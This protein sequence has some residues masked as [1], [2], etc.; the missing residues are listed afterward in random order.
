MR[1]STRAPARRQHQV[2]VT[3]PSPR[4]PEHEPRSH[5]PTSTPH[6]R[7]DGTRP[8]RRPTAQPE[9]HR[10]AT[11][12]VPRGS[13]PGKTR[14]LTHLA[15]EPHPSLHVSS[16]VGACA[17]ADDLVTALISDL[18]LCA[19]SPSRKSPARSPVGARR[20]SHLRGA[21]RGSSRHRLEHSF[22]VVLGPTDTSARMCSVHRRGTEPNGGGVVRLPG[23]GAHMAGRGGGIEMGRHL[24]RCHRTFSDP[25]PRIGSA[26]RRVR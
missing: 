17:G 20:T 9:R 25:N 10:R 15:P 19:V 18:P 16:R 26:A 21:G 6:T 14:R 3:T 11:A 23:V 2:L 5:R 22:S 12:A 13:A 8:D 7:F 1:T 24:R 4:R